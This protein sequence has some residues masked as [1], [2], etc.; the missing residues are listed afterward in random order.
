MTFESKVL[1]ICLKVGNGRYIQRY[2]FAYG[3]FLAFNFELELC[4]QRHKIRHFFYSNN[5]KHKN[6]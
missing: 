3:L 1:L 6:T 2:L 4:I 5:E